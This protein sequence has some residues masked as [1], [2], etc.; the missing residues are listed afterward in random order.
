MGLTTGPSQRGEHPSI[1]CE[2]LFDRQHDAFGMLGKPW[3]S[4]CPGAEEV[5]LD[6]LN[7][8]SGCR[9]QLFDRHRLA[10]RQEVGEMGQ[11]NE[12]WVLSNQT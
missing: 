12:F 9:G 2:I 1:H 4:R 11:Q 5:V 7:R 6:I 10:P 3:L 8:P